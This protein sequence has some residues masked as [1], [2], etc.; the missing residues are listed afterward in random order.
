MSSTNLTAV[1]EVIEQMQR[2]IEGSNNTNTGICGHMSTPALAL[3]YQI[4]EGWPYH[5]K[6]YE[7]PIPSLFFDIGPTESYVLCR[8]ADEDGLWKGPAR[9]LRRDLCAYVL[10]Y[11]TD[12]EFIAAKSWK[13]EAV[14][15]ILHTVEIDY[16]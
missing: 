12:P 3:F 14:E 13:N 8:K 4:A 11:L 16:V 2:C 10:T 7:W 15:H 6:K 9:T 1:H 5:S